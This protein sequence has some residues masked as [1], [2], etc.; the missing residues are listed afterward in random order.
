FLS[1]EEKIVSPVLFDEDMILIQAKGK[2]FQ[3]GSSEGRNDEKPVHAVK[4]TY[5]FYISK[6]EVTQREYEELMGENPSEFKGDSLPVEM[7]SWWDAIKYCN[8]RSRREALASCYDEN[9]G[10]CDFKSNG[11]RLPT[12][13]EWEYAA[14]GGPKSKGYTYSGSNTIDDVAWYGDFFREKAHPVGE[15]D[16]NELGLYDM[17]GNVWEWC[18]D[19]YG[20]KYYEQC[21]ERGTVLNPTGPNEGDYRDLRGGSWFNNAGDCRS[22]HRFRNPPVLRSYDAGFRLARGHIGKEQE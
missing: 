13:A 9:T 6:T 11:Y 8:A 12:E 15:K 7:V 3:M 4:F 16:P 17:S 19:W 21:K 18:N 14:R 20:L 22:A 5:D 1:C 2:S 10:E